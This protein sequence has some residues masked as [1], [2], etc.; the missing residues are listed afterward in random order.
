MA[1]EGITWL[2]SFPKSG[3]TWVRLFIDAYH[4]D[5]APDIN[6]MFGTITDQALRWYQA[7]SPD[8]VADMAP[9]ELALLHPA[10][11]MNLC[12]SLTYTPKLVK[13]HNANIGVSGCRLLPELLT[14]RVVYVVRD[15]RD[16]VIS[17]AKHFGIDIDTAIERLTDDR[18]SLFDPLD[19]GKAQHWTCSWARHV[20]SFV[21]ADDLSVTVIKYEE[22]HQDPVKYFSWILK[23]LEI[24]PDP[25][26]VQRAVDNCALAKLQD[27][28]AK[29]GFKE[30]SHKADRFFGEGRAGGWRTRLMADQIER[31]EAHAGDVMRAM[32]YELESRAVA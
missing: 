29:R 3:N 28:E 31:I 7:C 19:R 1:G 24:D 9:R 22:L 32:G 27:Q 17:Y 6:S 21:Q 8:P 15:P 18:V 12:N 14:E 30:C 11:M 4:H 10:A 2:A 26:R 20:Q 23:W 5:R 13:T 25:A 16:V